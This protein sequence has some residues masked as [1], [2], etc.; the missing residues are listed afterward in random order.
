M[1]IEIE[2]EDGHSA[3]RDKR[4]FWLK[5]ASA[6]LISEIADSCRSLWLI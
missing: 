2:I 1:Q 4:L 3:A 5:L 6:T